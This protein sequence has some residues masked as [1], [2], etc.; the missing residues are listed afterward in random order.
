MSAWA[1][2]TPEVPLMALENRSKVLVYVL[3]TV[4]II[5]TL[6][7]LVVWYGTHLGS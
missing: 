5:V 4:A 2:V 6:F 3:V 1:C 7:F